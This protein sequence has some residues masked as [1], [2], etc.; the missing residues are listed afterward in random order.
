MKKILIA[1]EDSVARGMLT[2]VLTPNSDQFEVMAAGNEDEALTI[3]SRHKI[4]LF[5]TDL[6]ISGADGFKFLSFIRRSYKD[7]PVFVM[8]AFGTPEVKNKVENVEKCRYFEKPLHIKVLT[9]S[10]LEE[11]ESVSEDPSGRISLPSFLRQIATEIKTCT[12]VI[13][14]ADK[15]GELFFLNGDLISAKTDDLRNKE[16]AYEIISWKKSNIEIHNAVPQTPKVIDEPLADVLMEGLRRSEE[17]DRNRDREK[18][19][20][21]EVGK[22]GLNKKTDAPEKQDEP[23]ADKD[24]FYSEHYASTQDFIKKIDE[25]QISALTS[26]AEKSETDTKE[27]L[28][29]KEAT[30]SYVAPLSRILKKMPGIVEYGIFSKNDYRYAGDSTSGSFEQINPAFCHELAQSLETQVKRGHFQ[31]LIIR[32]KENRY[33]L[34]YFGSTWIIIAVTPDFKVNRFMNKLKKK[35]SKAKANHGLI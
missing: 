32:E 31:H 22:A 26:E 27:E 28:F 23:D 15:K 6:H 5:I 4:N 35:N 25:V 17:K 11:L 9:K 2:R 29:S 33:V 16:A 14:S 7:M 10:I 21:R 20:S 12:L 1:D 24:P 3:L 30:P 19:R 13:Q 18:E 34:F 8:T